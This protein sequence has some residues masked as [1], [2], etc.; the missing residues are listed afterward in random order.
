MRMWHVELL[1]YLPDMQFR[2]QLRELGRHFGQSLFATQE[3]LLKI[4]NVCITLLSS[5]IL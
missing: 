3:S 1:P 5:V 4:L 2:G